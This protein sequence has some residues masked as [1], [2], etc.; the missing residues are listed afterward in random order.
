MR[1]LALSN[2]ENGALTTFIAYDIEY[3]E[4]N[5]GIGFFAYDDN[6]YFIPDVSL[7]DYNNICRS[8]MLNGYCD[9][10]RY[11]EILVDDEEENDEGEC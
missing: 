5:K 10:T 1:I 11:G 7:N 4:K 9:V 8:L 2:K 3:D 6:Y